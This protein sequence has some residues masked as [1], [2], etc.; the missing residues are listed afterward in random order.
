LPT[1]S[2]QHFAALK[3]YRCIDTHQSQEHAH[4]HVIG[5]TYLGHYA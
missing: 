3:Y 5:G 4:I 1:L 2:W